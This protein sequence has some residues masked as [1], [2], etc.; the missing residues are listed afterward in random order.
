MILETSR[1]GARTSF[2][3]NHRGKDRLFWMAMGEL[4]DV[5]TTINV[6]IETQ[7]SIL[8]ADHAEG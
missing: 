5:G 4:R 2:E 8:E 7:W 1:T 6:G 3:V